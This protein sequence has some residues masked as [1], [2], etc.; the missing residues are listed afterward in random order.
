MAT[1][2]TPVRQDTIFLKDN[3][4]TPEEAA[5]IRE[6]KDYSTW[7]VYKK[8]ARAKVMLQKSGLKKSGYNPYDKFYYFDLGDFLPRANE[9]FD[10]LGLIGVFVIEQ[11]TDEGVATETASLTIINIDNPDEFIEFS[12]PTAEA[13]QRNP[14]Q[15]LGS[16]HTYM[17]RYLYMEAL[18][19][20]ETDMVDAGAGTHMEEKQAE[21]QAAKQPTEAT[22][23][24]KPISKKQ[25][26]MLVQAYKLHADMIK[27]RLTACGKSKFDDLTMYEASKILQ[28][29]NAKTIEE[30]NKNA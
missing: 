23:K 8:L 10:E 25:K 27:E 30:A 29:V 26:D 2:K 14:I 15:G 20:A 6:A 12:S 19:I 1:A 11:R 7:S 9:I 3:Q 13:A 21:Q 16:K 22:L 4:Q 28:E 18:D 5:A 17:R 24:E